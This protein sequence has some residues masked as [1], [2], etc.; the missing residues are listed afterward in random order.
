MIERKRPQ[1]D[2]CDSE[3]GSGELD[4]LHENRPSLPTL[5]YRLGRHG[6]FFQRMLAR[7]PS[8]RNDSETSSRA[9]L[10]KLTYRGTDDPTVAVLD[11]C[12]SLLDVLAFY[13]ERIVNEGYIRTSIER[14][15]VLE[16]ARSIGYEMKPGVAAST[17][18]SFTVDEGPG[19]ADLITVPR[20]TQ[21]LSIP[22]KDELPRTYETTEDIEARPEWNA[23]EVRVAPTVQ[24]Q[25]LGPGTTAI[26]LASDAPRLSPG[27]PL[28]FV[29]GDGSSYFVR[30]IQSTT[31]LLDRDYVRV[32]LQDAVEDLDNTRVYAFLQ[33]SNL[34]GHNAPEPVGGLIDTQR[35]VHFRIETAVTCVALAPQGPL[36]AT[37]FEAIVPAPATLEA[38]EHG[39]LRIWPVDDPASEL[40]V[41]TYA[42][43]VAIS[44]SPDGKYLASCDGDGSVRVWD[45][46]TGQSAADPASDARPIANIIFTAIFPG[47]PPNQ[48]NLLTVDAG[49]LATP[50]HFTPPNPD[51]TLN[52]L[53]DLTA[54]VGTVIGGIQTNPLLVR[55]VDGELEGRADGTCIYRFR[56]LEV[57]E[58]VPDK[59][60]L[61]DGVV[62]LSEIQ[63][64]IVPGGWALLEDPEQ[65]LA[66]PI[67]SIS[68]VQR[69]DLGLRRRVSRLVVAL[70][71]SGGPP[72]FSLSQTEVYA[73]SVELELAEV[74]L[75]LPEPIEGDTVLLAR[76][77]LDDEV[78]D[79][80]EGRTVI[81]QG[82]PA[83]VK[84]IDA[85]EAWEES[86]PFVF[87]MTAIADDGEPIALEVKEDAATST[88]RLVDENGLS[89]ELGSDPPNLVAWDDDDDV[90]QEAAKVALTSVT[91]DSPPQPQLQFADELQHSYDWRSVRIIANVA[92]ATHGETQE[93]V[94]G[95]GDGLLPNQSF[96][97]KKPPLTFVSASNERGSQNTLEIRINGVLWSENDSLLTTE[98]GDEIFVVR[99]EDSGKTEITF[100]DG[101]R[102]A[103][104]PSGDENVVATYRSGIGPVGEL[105]AGQ[106]ALLKTRPLGVSD[107]T[108]PLPATGSAAAEQQSEARE[109]APRTVLVLGRV[110]SIQDYE[111]FTKSFPGVGKARAVAMWDGVSK[112]AHLTVGT[113]SGL[114]LERGSPLYDGLLGALNAVRDTNQLV[115]IDGFE[116]KFFGLHVNVLV[117]DR[118][119]AELVLPEIVVHLANSFAYDARELGQDV[120]AA[121]IVAAI[122][123]IAG[124]IAVDLDA[125]YPVELPPQDEFG[126]TAPTQQLTAQPARLEDGK[127]K[128]AELLLIDPTEIHIEEM[129]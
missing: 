113:E 114:T 17:L 57:P 99:I 102:G 116:P 83:G 96:T 11:A 76:N 122:H 92:T 40:A 48:P 77:D 67:D 72:E 43:M 95:S 60:P 18:L 126:D 104:L 7:L 21:V 93:E 97:L 34:F 103:R 75:T 25:G 31:D 32:T 2:C 58:P 80:L 44:F 68:V 37:G 46:T 108:N 94:L 1:T 119:L 79:G 52:P 109:N 64:E 127:P 70:G 106:L 47:Q 125:L 86:D 100:G 73:D 124:V 6:D 81:V 65:T 88:W 33:R 50:W 66:F 84:L 42:S 69:Q 14:R 128:A 38:S 5:S 74:S 121:E 110:V 53:V 59:V 55:N 20:G 115:V 90:I 45:T 19:T 98:P 101:L 87:A 51:G 107:V 22:K 123:E 82:R 35:I 26:F 4:T 36:A 56:A 117:D 112:F 8:Q 78:I 63:S 39:T 15:S 23:L 71:S 12:S 85:Y 61:E 118:Y 54:Q 13:Q 41:A 89:F 29:A 49:G 28:L 129:P 91:E 10:E 9:P 30:R 120:T 27:D 24:K 62:D 111:D 16:L 105:D 3:D